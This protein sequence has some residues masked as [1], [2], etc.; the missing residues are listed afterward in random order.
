MSHSSPSPPKR[1]RTKTVLK[2]V[3]H[4]MTYPRAEL[5]PYN[6]PFKSRS[7]CR[8]DTSDVQVKRAIKKLKGGIFSCLL[9]FI[10]KFKTKPL[11]CIIF[12]SPC[13]TAFLNKQWYFFQVSPLFNMDYS[14]VCMKRYARRLKEKIM[15]RLPDDSPTVY[16]VA[17]S[18]F[19]HLKLN[20]VDHEAIEVWIR[21]G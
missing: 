12:F 2:D 17:Y 13:S 21:T 4:E 1:S 11:T 19:P 14:E 6:T 20:D 5:T 7:L 9:F 15:S 18:T 16:Q 8:P 10:L 3:T